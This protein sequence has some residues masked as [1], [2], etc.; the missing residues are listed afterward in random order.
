MAGTKDYMEATQ[1][2]GSVLSLHVVHSADGQQIDRRHVL[3]LARTTLGRGEDQSLSFSQDGFLSSEHAEIVLLEPGSWLIRDCDSRNGTFANGLPITQRKLRPNDVIRIGNTVLVCYESRALEQADVTSLL[4]G[5]SPDMARLRQQISQ[6]AT[7]DLKVLILGETGTGKELVAREIHQKSARTGDFVPIN[8][9]AI[10][11][12]LV[13]STFFGHTR[14][15]FSGANSDQPGAFA[16]ADGGT[17]FLDE[18]G[19]LPLS[20]Q[21]TLLRVLEEGEITPVGASKARGV[22]V[23]V[24]AA[25][26]RDLRQA[27]EMGTFRGDLYA[28]LNQWPMELP[29]LRERREDVLLLFR[30][31]LG[32]DLLAQADVVEAMVIYDWPRNVRELSNLAERIKAV[33]PA[34]GALSWEEV[35]AELKALFDLRRNGSESPL[36]SSDATTINDEEREPPMPISRADIE[37]ALKRYQG[38]V[39]HCAEYL[40]IGRK[41]LYRKLESLNIDPARF[42]S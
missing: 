39:T 23:R 41:T 1:A 33:P 30:E 32:I 15:A 7:N 16:S 13:E 29:P 20:V 25:T 11:S 17:L 22:N 5:A 34:S 27:V 12:T 37:A 35:P 24:V 36:S 10:P 8:C 42:R 6:V 18:V 38:N 4:L 21:A 40:K 2:S 31:F 28:R 9:G 3:S 26:N 19:E 14:G